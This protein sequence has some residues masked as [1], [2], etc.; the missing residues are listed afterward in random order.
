MTKTD[1]MSVRELDGRSAI[2]RADGGLDMFKRFAVQRPGH[3]EH[4]V[5]V[6]VTESGT[7]QSERCDCRG[8]QFHRRCAHIDAVY[9]ARVL[10]CD[11]N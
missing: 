10:T 8:F 2:N 11:I 1:E 5:E 4:I 7:P 3:E 9:A 6:R